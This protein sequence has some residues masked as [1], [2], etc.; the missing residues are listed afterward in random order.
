MTVPAEGLPR[1]TRH[2]QH[3]AGRVSVGKMRLVGHLEAALRESRLTVDPRAPGAAELRE[4]LQNF[5]RRDAGARAGAAVGHDDLTI[6]L[7]LA[8]W[9]ADTCLGREPAGVGHVPVSG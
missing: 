3:R 1:K 4:E 2:Q 9:C 8:V 6:A 7:A 5:V